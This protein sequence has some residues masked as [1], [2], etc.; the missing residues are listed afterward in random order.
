MFSNFSFLSAAVKATSDVW[1]SLLENMRPLGV[2][3]PGVRGGRRRLTG[4]YYAEWV[5]RGLHSQLL[6]QQA[7]LERKVDMLRPEKKKLLEDWI[8]LE[9]DPTA[10]STRPGLSS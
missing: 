3:V 9:S 10:S 6:L 1:L 5:S 8:L 7:Q 4:P 2:L